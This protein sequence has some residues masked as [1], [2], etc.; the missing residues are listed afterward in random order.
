M[1]QKSCSN[2]ALIRHIKVENFRSIRNAEWYPKPGLNCLIG[3]GDSGKSSLLDAIDLVLGARRSYPFSDADFHL[4]NTNTPIKITAT[5]GALDEDLKNLEAY[6]NFFR[7]FDAVR[8]KI[9]DEPGQNDEVVLTIQLIV[10]EDL[11]PE[12]WLFSERAT[13]SGIER[14]L[15]WKHR[16]LLAPTRLGTTASHHLAW[17]SRSILNKLSEETFDV[18]TILAQLSRQTR[19]S[20]AAQE[21]PELGGVLGQVRTIANSLGVPVGELKALLDVNGV[22]LTNGAISLHNTDNTPLRQMGTGSSRLLISGLQKAASRSKVIIVDEAE[23]GLEPYRITRLLNELGSKDTNPIRQ[24]FI[25]THSPYVL[26]ELQASQLH[27][28]R[29]HI[30]RAGEPLS[31]DSHTVFSLSNGDQEQATLRACAEAFFSKAVIVGEGSTE[32][33]IVRGLDLYYHDIAAPG[34]HDRG[35]F[36]ADGGGDSFFK[37]AEVFASL[38]YPTAVVKDSDITTAAHQLQIEQCRAKGVFIF[39][40]GH[41]MSTEGAIFRWCPLN[42]IPS[43]LQLV[44]ALNS[45]QEVDQHIQNVSGNQLSLQMCIEQTA[46]AVRQPLAAAA[47]KYKWFKNIAKAELLARQILFPSYQDF[48]DEF[49]AVIVNLYQ[50]SVQ[51]GDPR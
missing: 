34:F 12:W 16:E 25:T 35:I 2:M 7:G 32:V 5:I 45:E 23:Y 1:V 47:G 11:E 30:A 22:S 13:Q 15:Q 21:L 49:K 17:G 41:G 37:R 19:E 40:W 4:M 42:V 6:G 3:P 44:V 10:S 9:N 28:L 29:K 27:V 36:C 18:S 43:M 14:R 26:R 33:G 31:L 20:F 46:D 38:G 39:E 8:E 50:W 51:N 24:V 48:S